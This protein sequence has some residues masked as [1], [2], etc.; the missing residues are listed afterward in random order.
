MRRTGRLRHSPRRSWNEARKSEQ[1]ARKSSEQG[2]A[3]RGAK[4][5]I[6]FFLRTIL[7]IACSFGPPTG[8][9][10]YGRLNIVHAWAST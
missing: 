2:R 6:R 1:G 5:V 7:R 3:S 4:S 8:L 9:F 10:S